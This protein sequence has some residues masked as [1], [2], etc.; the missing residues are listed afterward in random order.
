MFYSDDLIIG[1]V[2]KKIRQRTKENMDDYNMGLYDSF[3]EAVK[4]LCNNRESEL[5]KAWYSDDYRK[6]IPSAYETK[7]LDFSKYPLRY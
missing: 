1:K 7:Y 2:N 5:Y 4:T 3:K 6:F